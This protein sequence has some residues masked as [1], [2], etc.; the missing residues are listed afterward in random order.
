V[1]SLTLHGRE[2]DEEELDA[3]P[4]FPRLEILEL[5]SIA[6][7]DSA[8]T[9]LKK[10]PNLRVLRITFRET[11][12]LDFQNLPPLNQLE[13]LEFYNVPPRVR[14]L[15]LLPQKAPLLSGMDLWSPH[16]WEISV[17]PKM[18]AL[19]RL[20][21]QF[22]SVPQE[23][24]LGS[25]HTLTDLALGGDAFTDDIVLEILNQ[26]CSL[27]SLVLRGTKIGN[28]VTEKL[29][30]CQT[31]KFVDVVDTCVTEEAIQSLR[32]TRPDMKVSPL[33]GASPARGHHRHGLMKRLKRLKKLMNRLFQRIVVRNKTR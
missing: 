31:I 6:I 8:F 9:F 2:F 12:Q 19:R 28:R 10:F 17:F 16:P 15:N 26:L 11:N 24:R 7:E 1:W 29:Q 13:V 20:F 27:H 14:G 18:V 23:F 32:D 22:P 3:L 30:T 5:K 33:G 25:L 21:L 4:P